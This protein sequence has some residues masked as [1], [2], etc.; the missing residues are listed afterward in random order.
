MRKTVQ[1]LLKE[2]TGEE[3]MVCDLSPVQ[4]QGL[5]RCPYTIHPKTGQN[6]FIP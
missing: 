5:I 2:A 4:R 1:R 3:L 6:R